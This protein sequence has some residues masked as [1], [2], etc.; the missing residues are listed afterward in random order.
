MSHGIE[1]LLKHRG[2][3]FRARC[4]FSN[5]AA[6]ARRTETGGG[7]P[8]NEKCIFKRKKSGQSNITVR[9]QVN[10]EILSWASV[11]LHCNFAEVLPEII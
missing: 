6:E 11:G 4:Q 8:E 10:R 3:S 1:S 7:L 9:L 2:F 5:G